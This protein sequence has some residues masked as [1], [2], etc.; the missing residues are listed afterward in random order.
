MNKRPNPEQRRIAVTALVL[1][2]AVPGATQA[3][4]VR[5]ERAATDASLAVVAQATRGE[6]DTAFADAARLGQ[7]RDAAL[8]RVLDRQKQAAAEALG[9][10]GAVR[11]ISTPDEL[12]F[13]GCVTRSYLVRHAQGTS[14]WILKWRRGS[15]GWYL[16]D[17]AV[18]RS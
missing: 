11:S 3:A 6:L 8:P 17:L 10:L 18:S 13:A 16:K 4:G 1:C 15:G 7:E 12:F 14:R 9:R 5:N 2:L